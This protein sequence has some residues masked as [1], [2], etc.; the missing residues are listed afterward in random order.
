MDAFLDILRAWFRIIITCLTYIYMLLHSILFVSN[1]LGPKKVGS[2]AGAVTHFFILF[3]FYSCLL[4][5]LFVCLL[6][7]V[8]FVCFVCFVFVYQPVKYMES[9]K[10]MVA[11]RG[12]T[13]RKKSYKTII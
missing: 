10:S 13:H 7:V 1:C 3:L 4:F 6:F 8:C 2:K 11:K 12:H 5:V 9:H